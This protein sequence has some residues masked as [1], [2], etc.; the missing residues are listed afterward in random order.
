MTVPTAI[1]PC[2]RYADA[3][4]AIDFLSAA[5]G[6]KVQAVHADA[7]DP[8]VVLH[9]QLLLG[10]HMVML[11]SD[12]AGPTRDRF[13]WRLPSQ[14][15][16]ITMCVYVVIDDVDAHC[17]RA[18]AAG[19]EILDEPHDN[20]GYAGRG[21]EARDPEGHVWSFGSYDPHAEPH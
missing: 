3:P 14:V 17:E 4:R 2:L 18:R 6:F 9:A 10:G 13:R 5:F 16:G 11:G 1:I 15:G 8:S 21:Y 12:R 19:A 7:A 20:E